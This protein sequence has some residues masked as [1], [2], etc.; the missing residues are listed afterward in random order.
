MKLQQYNMFKR[1]SRNRLKYLWTKSLML[2]L[3]PL[4]DGN[5]FNN[6]FAVENANLLKPKLFMGRGHFL[7]HFCWKWCLMSRMLYLERQR[8]N[9]HVRCWRVRNLSHM[10]LT[11]SLLAILGWLAD[12]PWKGIQR[13]VSRPMGNFLK[14]HIFAEWGNSFSPSSF[15]TRFRAYYCK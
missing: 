1:N 2:H 14:S 10:C 9:T 6:N 12:F 4:L 5:F 7:L 15:T 8:E 3:I 11:S 13:F